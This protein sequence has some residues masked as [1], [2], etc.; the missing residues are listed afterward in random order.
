MRPPVGLPTLPG[1]SQPLFG[2]DRAAAAFG[3]GVVLEDDRPEPLEHRALD[4]HGRGRRAVQHVA[5]RREVVARA[6][7]RRERE[8]S[9]EHR[10]DD[11]RVGDAVPLRSSRSV[12]SG[13]H[14]SMSTMVAPRA[15]RPHQVIGERGRVIERAGAERDRLAADHRHARD[16][17]R[18]RSARRRGGARPWGGRSCPTCRASRCRSSG[19]RCR[20][21]ARRRARPS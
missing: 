13:S 15:Q 20:R 9:V 7:L 17:A 11:V 1:R 2:R 5:Q 4:V 18:D 12:S 3:A 21:C 10:R 16:R 19:R 8:Q 6:D 14:L